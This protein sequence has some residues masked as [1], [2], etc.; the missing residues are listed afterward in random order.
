M[1]EKTIIGIN[2]AYMSYNIPPYLP[3]PLMCL[4]FAWSDINIIIAYTKQIM[5]TEYN[6]IS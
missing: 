6:S 3:Y 5:I 2:K 1:N 4:F